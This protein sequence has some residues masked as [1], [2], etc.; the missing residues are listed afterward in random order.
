M[1]FLSR[2]V[3]LSAFLLLLSVAAQ[4]PAQELTFTGGV[5]K[6]SDFE[7][8]S[9]A[10][11]VDYRQNFYR[12]F[13]G[14]IAYLNEGH[15][16]GHHR[17]GTAWQ[18]WGRLPFFQD[19]IAMSLG[20]GA[21]YF[22]DTQ[23]L[24]GG[25][26]ANVHGTAPIYSFSATS[27]LSNRWFYRFQANYIVPAKE[28]KVITAAIG[29]G[30]W[31]GRE[32]KPTP[33]KLGDAPDDKGYITENELTFFT[34]QSVVNT[35]LNPQSRAYAVEYR[36]GLVRH[37]DWTVSGIYEGDP[38]IIRRNGVAT[39]VWA[40]NTFFDDR[41]AVGAGLGPYIFLDHKRPASVRQKNPA[42]IAPLASLT[43]SVRLSDHWIARLVFDR[44]TSSYNRDA[45]IFL[46]GLGYRWPL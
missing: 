7:Q 3:K 38:E 22:F 40:V 34:G 29:A 35:F 31:F 21:Y 41:I 12:N 36:R 44:V 17:D 42:A 9:Y 25:D 14:S 26:T 30:F 32:Q 2:P 1:H 18:L 20:A 15:V 27:Y 46:I 33:G 23:P 16:P 8:S 19:R 28:M 39:Q 4:L 37:V 6:T 13:A 5:M 43:V 45:D 10:W 24:P 11:Q